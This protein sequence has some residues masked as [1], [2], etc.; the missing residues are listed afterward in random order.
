MKLFDFEKS[1]PQKILDRGMDYHYEGAVLELLDHEEGEWR[2][3]VLG[4]RSAPYQVQISLN[5]ED[6]LNWSCTCPYTAGAVCKHVVAALY[7]LREIMEL[8]AEENAGQEPA[9]ADIAQPEVTPGG[10]FA[11]FKDLSDAE[12]RSVKIAALYWHSFAPAQFVDVF[13]RSNFKYDGLPLKPGD[14]RSLADKLVRQGFLVRKKGE[15]QCVHHFAHELCERFFTKDADFSKIVWAIRAAFR[16]SFWQYAN[17]PADFFREMRFA[18][19]TND[20]DVFRQNH[21]NLIRCH[22]REYSQA[23]LLDFW[24]S[25][26]FD[27]EK[28]EALPDRIRDFL[29]IEKL[30]LQTFELT[31]PGGWFHYAVSRLPAMHHQEGF[32]A[33]RLAAQILLF[34]GD[35]KGLERVIAYAKPSDSEALR[36]AWRLLHGDTG[37]ALQSFDASLKI[38]R[39]EAGGR[40][41]ELKSLPGIFQTLARFK[42]RDGAWLP[43]IG[44]HIA[45]VDKDYS[46][47]RP[48]YRW[49]DAVRL[50][51]QNDQKTAVYKLKGPE[52]TP[53]MLNFFK[54][55]CAYWID[56]RLVNR[57]ELEAFFHQVADNG[58]DWLAAQTLALWNHLEPGD[59]EREKTEARYFDQLGAVEPLW[60]LLPRIEAW[61]NSLNMLSLIGESNQKSAAKN[62]ARLVWMV[63]FQKGRIMARQ[64]SYGKN[65]WTKGR[66]VAYDRLQ[67]RELDCLTEQ[68]QRII[69]AVG[70]ADGAELTLYEPL[71]WRELCNHPLLFLWQSPGTA[72]QL[73]EGELHLNVREEGDGYRVSLSHPVKSSGLQIIKEMPTRYLLIDVDERLLNIAR[74]IGG[75]SLLVPPQGAEQLKEVI[76]GLSGI[77]AVQSV[78]ED[79]NLPAVEPDARIHLHLLPVGDGFHVETYTKPF[80]DAPPYVRPGEGAPT[81]ITLLEGRRTSTTRDL[82]AEEEALRQLLIQ[83]PI[84]VE[85][86]PLQG[87][88]ELEETEQCLQLLLQIEPMVQSG[89]I[90]LEWPKGEKFRIAKVAE[91]NQL[92][93]DIR[94]RGHWFEVD[95]ELAVDEDRVLT[96][97]ELLKLSEEQG[98]FIE[99][100]SGKFLALT[101]EFKRRLREASGL[102][103]MQK[104]GGA[105]QLHPLAAPALDDF[106][107]SL[108]QVTTDEAF[109]D[110]RERL[111]AAFA[112][113]FKPSKKFK[114]TLR[115]YQREGF[116]WLHRCAAWG[117]GACL[118]DDMGL[119]K[120]IQALAVLTDRAQQG[121]ALVV[122]PASVCRNWR[123]ETEKFAP[124]LRPVLFGEGDREAM[125]VEAGPGD[126]VIVTY[127]LMTREH[128][129]FVKKTFATVILDE[130]QAIKN[131][132]TKRSET[133]MQLQADFRMILTGTPLENHLG[134]LWNLFQF[135]NPGLLGTIEQ[136][137]EQ[138]TLPIEKYRDEERREQLRKLAQPFILRRRKDEVLK[139]LPE[140]TEV[141]LT[142]E[143]PPEERAFYE[144]LRRSAIEKLTADTDAKGGEQ[145]LRILAE[146]M[147]LRRAACHPRLVDE[148]AGFTSSAKL[149]LFAEIVEELLDNGHKALVFSQFVGH[150]KI[151]EAYLREKKISYQYLD[152]Q[153]P[154]PKR[155]ERIEAFQAGEGDLFLISLKAGGVGLNL[156][157]ADYVI[158]T[159]PWWNP[160][161]EDQATDR[162]HRIG[163]EKPVTVYRLVAE[164][165]IEE[166]ILQLHE[167]KRDLADSLLAGTDVSARMTAADLLALMQDES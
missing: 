70:F 92:R 34:R 21:L 7:E 26:Q 147:R 149:R 86:Q 6:V 113:K 108:Q 77:V 117:V 96:I 76:A 116:E 60:R 19:Y 140:K 49:L 84:L 73:L 18:R 145:H 121:P 22:N 91:L 80:R 139:E 141:T 51:L 155:Q 35:W 17:S 154:L 59:E 38:I 48:V 43:K 119:G 127:D 61:E 31:A 118:A 67:R 133:A 64:Q 135:I 162:A 8:E 30:N 134:E 120:T 50:F 54:F 62:D 29:L 66:P 144:A 27:T 107:G 12:Q 106:I 81:L 39:K 15:H 82:R 5:G 124:A 167:Q 25:S 97:Q 16:H 65:G 160:A 158:H 132:A 111:E 46:T 100:S 58:Y 125:I 153:T 131:R 23:S 102:L 11:R 85:L 137:N 130:A 87:I 53:F 115:S 33:A 122:A 32:S 103:K 165:T 79:E 150:L 71:V 57:R 90:V 78:F 110:A 68:D 83:T 88:W 55:F 148:N 105:L 89:D 36:G 10:L 129:H 42:T 112:K 95:G 47:Y 13:N 128:D 69:A 146:L 4:S 114:A 45:Q 164:N 72:V 109:R 163:Q 41:E 101:E 3:L 123:A 44:K 104:K 152:G 75:D 24:L 136:F 56:D 74:A 157:A 9:A 2:A 37:G 28:L 63:D 14:F 126:L 159:D 20:P 93:L 98:Q 142:V 99:L 52:H 1:I 156:T 161:V 138:F 166:K 151:L 143:L 40:R 94:G